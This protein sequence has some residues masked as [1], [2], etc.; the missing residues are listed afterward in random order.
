MGGGRKE[1]ECAHIPLARS[2]AFKVTSYK[3]HPG[4]NRFWGTG[5]SPCVTLVPARKLKVKHKNL[6]GDFTQSQP[7]IRGKP[8]ILARTCSSLTSAASPSS[9]APNQAHPTALGALGLQGL[10]EILP[11]DTKSEQLRLSQCELTNFCL[12]ELYLVQ[13][14]QGLPPTHL[15]GQEGFSW[16]TDLHR[17]QLQQL[18]LLQHPGTLRRACDCGEQ[19]AGKPT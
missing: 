5:T 19:M 8:Q 2:W 11:S 9:S 7:H 1:E 10:G 17:P 6:D 16:Q 13:A 14:P 4:A 15:L 18:E 3:N 12:L